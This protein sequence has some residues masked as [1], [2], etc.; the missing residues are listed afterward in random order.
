MNGDALLAAPPHVRAEYAR[1]NEARN[2]AEL[3]LR[4]ACDDLR[5]RGVKRGLNDLIGFYVGRA[6]VELAATP[7]SVVEVPTPK[8]G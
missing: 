8:E 1:V 5:A 3:A 6:A 2:V 4:L 7:P